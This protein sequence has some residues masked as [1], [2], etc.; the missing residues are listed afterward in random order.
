MINTHLVLVCF[1]VYTFSV[2]NTMFPRP[3]HGLD[4]YSCKERVSSGE[5]LALLLAGPAHV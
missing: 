3:G 1:S 2:S 4:A 5:M